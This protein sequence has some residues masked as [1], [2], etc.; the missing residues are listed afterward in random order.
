[1]FLSLELF[2]P[3]MKYYLLYKIEYQNTN[4]IRETPYIRSGNRTH[5]WRTRIPLFTVLRSFHLPQPRKPLSDAQMKIPINLI[6]LDRSR[7]PIRLM[8]DTIW[9]FEPK[10]G[11]RQIINARIITFRNLNFIQ[12]SSEKKKLQN[13]FSIYLAIKRYSCTCLDLISVFKI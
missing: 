10:S 6:G 2:S 1:M 3:E 13:W 8:M 9:A 11:L 4:N 5:L 7:S 12:F